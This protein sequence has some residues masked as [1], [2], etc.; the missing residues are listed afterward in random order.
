MAKSSSFT[1]TSLKMDS[2]SVIGPPKNGQK[3]PFVRKNS[4][5]SPLFYGQMPQKEALSVNPH[6]NGHK[7]TDKSPENDGLSVKFILLTDKS[8]KIGSLSVKLSD[9]LARC[10]KK[11]KSVP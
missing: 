11:K 1:D 7:F 6:H 9:I 4:D 3:W 2:L 5:V 8:A 10:S